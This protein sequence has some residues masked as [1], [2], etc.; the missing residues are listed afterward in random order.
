[1]W[2][3]RWLFLLACAVF[4]SMAL[5]A[6]W[7]APADLSTG[8]TSL[9]RYLDFLASPWGILGIA[10]VGA[11]VLFGVWYLRFRPHLPAPATAFDGKLRRDRHL[12]VLV[13]VAFAL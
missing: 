6:V 11:F 12:L 8:L 13:L 7:F 10:A 3:A 4:V 9:R 2:R 5:L 1:M